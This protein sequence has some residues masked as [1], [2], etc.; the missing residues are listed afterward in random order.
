MSDCIF[1]QILRGDSPASFVYRDER[2]T[3][4]LDIQPVNPGH[5]LVISD[6]HAPYL[7]DLDAGTAAHLM[8]VAH[9]LTAALRGSGLRCEG[10]NLF[11][12]DGEAA[13]QEVFH[14]HLHVLP[15]YG[16]DE[17]RRRFFGPDYGTQP[18]RAELDEAARQIREAWARMGVHQAVEGA[19]GVDVEI[20][21]VSK[22]RAGRYAGE[23]GNENPSEGQHV[24]PQR[25]SGSLQCGPSAMTS[26]SSGSGIELT[27]SQAEA[28]PGASASSASEGEGRPPLP[29]AR[30]IFAYMLAC[31][32]RGPRM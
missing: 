18:P 30:Q 23:N 17:F 12:A 22:G 19:R 9:G 2:C 28:P 20:G 25:R 8:R 24:L 6:V 32:T 31:Q 1:C 10:V 15:R 11:L 29:S 16:G 26:R 27:H 13:M 4:F 7:A 14:V 3:A 21:P 5:L